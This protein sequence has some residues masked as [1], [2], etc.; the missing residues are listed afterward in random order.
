MTVYSTLQYS[1]S[2]SHCPD[3]IS[4]R[5]SLSPSLF[6]CL[7]CVQHKLKTFFG[8]EESSDTAKAFIGLI[9]AL[10]CFHYYI[11]ITT[12]HTLTSSASSNCSALLSSL[13]F[14][15]GN[16][17]ILEIWMKSITHTQ[18][19]AKYRNELKRIKIHFYCYRYYSC[20]NFWRRHYDGDDF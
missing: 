19:G 7:W 6:A 1:L 2:P 9:M 10:W 15:V 14:K 17:K 13:F 16:F 3:L 4:L 18:A 20:S 12:R 11:L 5:P 8:D